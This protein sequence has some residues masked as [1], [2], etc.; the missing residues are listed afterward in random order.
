VWKGR[1]QGVVYG[2]KLQ[3]KIV[4]LGLRDEARS[5]PKEK[6]NKKATE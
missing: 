5:S 1:D 2:G 4:L 3:E 6:S